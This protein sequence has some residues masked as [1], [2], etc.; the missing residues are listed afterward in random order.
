MSG[1]FKR[2][3]LDQLCE[4]P[5]EIID[6]YVVERHIWQGGSVDD[7]AESK[8][9][10]R[11]EPRTV[12]DFLIDPV[13]S[14]LNDVLRQLAMPYNPSDKTNPIGQGWWVQAEFG[15]GKSHLLSVVGALAL[16]DKRVWDIVLD[17]ETKNKKGKRESI[18]NFYENGLAKKSSGK[19]KG[20][21]VAV[22]TL[23]GQGGGTIGV[24]DT[25]RKLTEYILDAVQDQYHAETGRTISVYPVEVL[26]GRFEEEL[27]LY[28]K[29]LAKFLKDP[30][31]FDDNEQIE[32]DEFLDNSRNSKKLTVRRDCGQ[33][34]WDF[35][36][37]ELKTT[38]DIP[39]EAEAVL[40]HVVETLIASGFEGLLLILD[41]IMN[42][43]M[44][45][46][47]HDKG[48]KADIKDNLDHYEV[49][50]DELAK[51]LPQVKK[52]GKN[53]VFTPEGGGVDVKKLF[54]QARSL[55]ENNE[56]QQR[57]AWHQ[58]LGL[59]GWEI[60]TSIL[61]MDLAR[62]TRSIFRGIAPAEQKDALVEWHGRTIKGRVYMR[63]LLDIA[64]RGQALPPLNTADTDHDFAVFIGNRPCGDK[65]TG[66]AKKVGDPRVLFWT[67]AP[68]T[69]QE[70]DRLLDFAAYRELVKDHL[71]K[72]TEDAKEVIQWVANRLRD[73]IGSS[74]KIVTDSY[75]RGQ[76][77]AADHSN[78]S[79]NCQGELLAVLTPR[80]GQVL[81]AVYES[82]KIEF[83]GP[84]SFDDAEAIKL[85]NGIVK[86][87][88]IPKGTKPNQFTS[89]ADNYGYVLGI[90]KKD[91]TKRLNTS[92]NEFVEDLDEW[93]ETQTTHGNRQI[94]V[95]SV[96]KNFTGL[97]GPNDKN[98]GLS[99]RMI[100][101]YLL[102]LV[103]EGKLR[104]LLSGKG[105]AT[106]EYIDYTNIADLTFNAALLNSKTKVQR[107]KAPEGWPV[108]APYAAILLDDESL[109]SI[110]VGKDRRHRGDLAPAQCPGH[111][112]RLY[113]LRLAGGQDHG[114]RR[115]GDPQ[116]DQGE[117]RRLLSSRSE[118]QGGSPLLAAPGEEGWSGR[119][120]EGQAPQPGEESGKRQ[121][122]YGVGSK[123]PKPTARPAR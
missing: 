17:L 84:A 59:D 103:R 93:I 29:R 101:I 50:L 78:L 68:L 22:K 2:Q 40:K 56:V 30:K 25:G 102:C 27:D 18:H 1:L 48:Q 62:S 115:S 66:L 73:E 65:V 111:V 81:D 106:T 24:T 55:A 85:I 92:G 26:A 33:K 79:F 9:K 42:S 8:R 104:I 47:D 61:T 113:L 69:V 43:V 112:V 53:F 77:S 88:D 31:H 7:E 67:P 117:G 82:S 76:I 72:D 100:D 19:S 12:R 58:L 14:L 37:K 10:R 46:A 63:D 32:I 49:L 34:L 51:E 5:D 108:L 11:A 95:E 87:G 3:T 44:E 13:R 97:G 96:C 57:D 89:A 114:T 83:D 116:E 123:A 20:I 6:V 54:Q 110:P 122:P 107:L 71:H 75:A 91:G 98:Y 41:E 52:V 121:R 36:R 35:Y 74:A 118:D 45:W 99:R 80:I 120:A 28:Y 15:S 16:G 60:K 38:P 105:A 70:K 94:S 64:S 109:K 86:T 119:R 4:V 23:V 21:F 90:M 39:R